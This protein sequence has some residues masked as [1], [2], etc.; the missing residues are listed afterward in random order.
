M[1]LEIGAITASALDAAVA[2]KDRKDP[3]DVQD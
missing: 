1:I 3:E 2:A